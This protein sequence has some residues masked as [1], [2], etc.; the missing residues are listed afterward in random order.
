MVKLINPERWI[1][2]RYDSD[3]E[4]LLAVIEIVLSDK[5]KLFISDI[6]I[7]GM[8]F[9]IIANGPLVE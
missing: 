5:N 9:S 1:N 3:N 6:I 4:G 7:S 2:N 8:V